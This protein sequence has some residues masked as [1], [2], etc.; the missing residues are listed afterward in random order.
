MDEIQV[1][2]GASHAEEELFA[3]R[4]VVRNVV[5]SKSVSV[6]RV[7]VLMGRI[8][9]VTRNQNFSN[10]LE[11]EERDDFDV[12]EVDQKKHSTLKLENQIKH[13]SE[14]S[15]ENYVDNQFTGNC[16]NYHNEATDQYKSD[17]SDQIKELNLQYLL[18]NQVGTTEDFVRKGISDHIEISKSI[19]NIGNGKNKAHNTH[20]DCKPNVSDMVLGLHPCSSLSYAVG[21]LLS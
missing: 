1:G 3:V 4:D 8:S 6:S 9:E 20:R 16:N 7:S 10:Q 19:E 18:D 12:K 14:L 13:K 2:H 21:I 11:I 5:L 17:A 15:E